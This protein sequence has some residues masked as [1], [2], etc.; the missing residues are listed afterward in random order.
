MLHS[1]VRARHLHRIGGVRPQ[2]HLNPVP[3]VA[4]FRLYAV[5]GERR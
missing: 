5:S 4:D 2:G 3:R 1:R